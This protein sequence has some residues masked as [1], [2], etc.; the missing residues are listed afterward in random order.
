LT[1]DHALTQARVAR[2]LRTQDYNLEKEEIKL[3]SPSKKM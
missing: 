2:I 3:W 1:E